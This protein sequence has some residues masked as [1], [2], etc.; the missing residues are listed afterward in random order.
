MITHCK[1]FDRRTDEAVCLACE[2]CLPPAKRVGGKMCEMHVNKDPITA[3][4]N[5]C[6]NACY[7][8]QDLWEVATQIEDELKIN[9][10]SQGLYDAMAD[11]TFDYLKRFVK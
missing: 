5:N 3:Y 4:L 2:Y 6:R 8:R 7:D 1:R 11:A 10:V 9:D